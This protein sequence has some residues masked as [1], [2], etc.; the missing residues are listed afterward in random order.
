VRD[1]N[2]FR[3]NVLL[4]FDRLAGDAALTPGPQ[5]ALWLITRALPSL[6]G[7]IDASGRPGNVPKGV[8]P[9]SACA[10]FMLTPDAKYHLITAPVNFGPQ[11]YHEKV[12]VTLGHPGYVAETKRALLLRDTSHHE[13]FV[14]ILQTFRGASA[15]QVP[16]L[17]QNK[18][19]GTLICA[20]S[21]RNT[22]DEIDLQAIKAFAGLATS[23]WIAH[24]GPAWLKTLDYAKLSLRTKGA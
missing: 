5:E 15:M 21:V 4:A 23:L 12:A 1:I 17:W 2:A 3:E 14:K 6:L 16:M 22:Y 19:L 10:A 9:A 7:D 13:S 18:Y 11:Q 20:S 8:S 24:G